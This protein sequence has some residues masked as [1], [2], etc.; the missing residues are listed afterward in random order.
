MRGRKVPML[1]MLYLKLIERGDSL[2]AH[3]ASHSRLHTP[4]QV[5]DG[6]K[7]E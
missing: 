1:D 7:K 6:Y 2:P 3:H 5:G 4:L